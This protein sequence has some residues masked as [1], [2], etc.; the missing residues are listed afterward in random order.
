MTNTLGVMQLFETIIERKEMVFSNCVR[1]ELASFKTGLNTGSSIHLYFISPINLA[2]VPGKRTIN[3]MP[4]LIIKYIVE[5][6]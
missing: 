3:F 4:G 5:A 1:M 6:D 2:F